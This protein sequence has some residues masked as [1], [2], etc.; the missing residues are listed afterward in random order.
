MA[1]YAPENLTISITSNNYVLNFEIFQWISLNDLV[2]A[3][4]MQM[5]IN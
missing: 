1:G 5:P 4:K 2:L 3:I